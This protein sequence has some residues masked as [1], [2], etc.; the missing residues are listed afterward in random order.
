MKRAII[1]VLIVLALV[2][3][4]C[5]TKAEPTVAPRAQDDFS[6]V[7]SVT[8]ELVPATWATLSAKA[9]GR[10][11]GVL[12][13]PGDVVE[14]G[15]PVVRLDTT[16]LGLSLR[17]ARQEVAA[18]QAA[19]ARLVAGASEQAA[20]R[21]DR[22]NAQ[23]IAQAEIALRVKQEQ[24]EQ[25]L[26][27]DPGQDVA[28]A[29]AL[30][31][32]AQ[33]QLAQARAQDPAAEVRAA[34]VELERAKI[35]LD[36]AQDEYNKALDRPWEDQGIRDAWAK[37]L[38]QMQLTYRA[39]QAQLDG[40][41]SAQRAHAL[42]LDA[43]AAQV[44]S[45]Q[46]RLAQAQEAESAYDATLGILGDEVEAARLAVEYLRA[47]ENP[48]RDKAMGEEIDQAEARLEQA[49]GAVAQIE[50][51]IADAELRAPFAGTV[52]SVDVRAGELVQPGQPLIV[53]GDLDTLRVE[54]TDLDEIDVVRVVV[55]QE[56]AITFDALPDRVITGIVTR[57][58]PMAESGSGGVHYTVV[59]ELEELDPVLRWGMT[60]FVDIEVKR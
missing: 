10:V 30:V 20:A 51:Q 47:W 19:L 45:A 6:P 50:Q 52:G 60:A 25:A 5:G 32:Q 28:A 7:V 40:A 36:D 44:A 54:T 34:Q 58:S 23:Q 26:G 39:A 24:L 42:S 17:V 27:R 38:E 3:A 35:A 37:Q 12:V 13:E 8:G 4:G 55:G 48:L 33:A 41:T 16:D 21:A 11:S 29:Q 15:A 46:A 59:L 18:Q 31:R 43:L 49:R 9:G 2:L 57:I 22:E 53:I 56:A 14:A 1:A